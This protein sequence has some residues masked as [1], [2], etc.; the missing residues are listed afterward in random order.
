MIKLIINFQKVAKKVNTISI[1]KSGIFCF[2]LFLMVGIIG[3]VS[4]VF[5]EIP[6]EIPSWVKN[7]AKY[8]GAESIS[9]QEFVQ[10]IQWL[11][12]EDFIT[13]PQ[14]GNST[15]QAKEQNNTPGVFS[16][17]KCTKGYQYIK[18][19][20]KYTNGDTA[21]SILSLK[22]AILD[23][24]RDVLATGSGLITNI[25]ANSAKF[26]DGIAIFA[27]E[28][29]DSCEVEVS[30]ALPKGR[31]L[32]NK[33]IQTQ[34]IVVEKEKEQKDV[35]TPTVEPPKEINVKSYSI[36]QVSSGLLVSDSLKNGKINDYWIFGGSA[37]NVK[38]DYDHFTD[39]DGLHIGVQAPEIGIYAGHYAL[40]PP[41]NGTLF[42][43]E[44]TSPRSYISDGYLQNG[45]HVQGSDVSSNYLTC[46][47]IISESGKPTWALT[48]SNV[49][50][51]GIS[52]YEVLWS[53]EKPT[54]TRECTIITNGNNFLRVFLDNVEVY[55]KYDLDLKMTGSFLSLLETQS[56][57]P[58]QKLY[59]TF[60]D[61]YITMD[62][63][64]QVINLPGYITKVVLTDTYNEILATGTINEGTSIIDVSGLHYPITGNIK[65]FQKD[66]ELIST[67]SPITMYGGD[68]YS[69]N[70]G[71]SEQ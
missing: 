20:G 9:D 32:E 12:D 34:I 28:K 44:I 51:K 41:T 54:L 27:G 57:Y 71:T 11:I 16:N 36:S 14:Q 23:E 6:L 8:W 40:V 26:F 31:L 49:D 25:E 1:I 62:S 56:S 55:V 69:V 45:L 66:G 46:V 35:E 15:Q 10:V 53:E 29:F 64:I 30:S 68:V 13:L 37:E 42:H 60:N 65:A 48:Y 21:Y 18:M 4:N 22:I 59:G 47:S 50:A 52:Q 24:N 63:T 2:A 67:P 70:R 43:A 5:G 7:I 33:N 3:N 61:F 19:T 38:A 17:V 58:G 39:N